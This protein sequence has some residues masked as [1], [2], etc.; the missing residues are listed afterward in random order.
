MN[1]IKSKYSDVDIKKIWKEKQDKIISIAIAM[2]VFSSFFM[3]YYV[4][5]I[6][7]F[8]LYMFVIVVA[9]V[10]IMSVSFSELKKSLKSICV[11]WYVA[12]I[13][14]AIN[15][16]RTPFDLNVY[17]DLITFL[18]CII[19]VACCGK[20]NKN[21][22]LAM[23]I[24]L[25]FS[26]YY[27]VSVWFQYLFPNMYNEVYLSWLPAR[28]RK[29]IIK[30]VAENAG[31]VGFS[32]NAG[33]TASHIA[34][35]VILTFSKLK[36]FSLKLKE[37]LKKYGLLLFLLISMFMT[38]KRA[39]CIFILGS[40][41]CVLLALIEKKYR[42]TT[43][44]VMIVIF[45][46][47]IISIIVFRDSLV[48]VPFFGRI[49]ETVEGLM[50]GKDVSSNRFTLYAFALKL[51]ETNPIFGVG[52]CNFRRLGAGVITKVTEL[53]AH[54][55]YLQM[56]CEIGVIGFIIVLTPLLVF[57]LITYKQLKKC[58][59]TGTNMSYEWRTLL[60]FSF[61][62]Q[63]YF[64]L[65]GLLDNTLYDHNYV[66]ILFFCYAITMTRI[67]ESNCEMEDI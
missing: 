40:L 6:K 27:A 34:A 4:H 15:I 9:A 62:Y 1:V 5:I 2:F 35:G 21:F 57:V 49:I 19:M 3:Q 37:N 23:K 11:F 30:S 66:L 32:T 12:I 65:C 7:S 25:L 26:V 22:D 41:F 20:E 59:S 8:V 47:S 63:L 31:F 10:L 18:T 48:D 28:P 51:F 53:E 38:G 14:I 55:I 24:I 58:V 56:L 43:I 13:C 61:G 33:Y 46:I 67:R 50:N 60:A 45:V 29:S 52:W 54:N 16:I 17:V 64:L 39:A 44:S 36:N 42:K